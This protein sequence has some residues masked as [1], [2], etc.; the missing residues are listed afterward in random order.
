MH[1][2]GYHAAV[3]AASILYIAGAALALWRTDAGWPSRMVLALLWPVGPVAF[4]VTMTI[5]LAAS[6]IA[7]PLVGALVGAAGLL[8]WW[9]VA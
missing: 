7:F 6:L 4:L 9:W 2:A 1:T 5:L 3:T 8:A